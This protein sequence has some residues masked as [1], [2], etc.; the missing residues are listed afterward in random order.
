VQD[1]ISLSVDSLATRRTRIEI[2]EAIQH[3]RE[4]ALERG[5]S[6]YYVSGLEMALGIIDGTVKNLHKPHLTQQTL[7]DYDYD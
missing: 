1:H 6:S 2:Y 3:H 7:F 4:L 5:M